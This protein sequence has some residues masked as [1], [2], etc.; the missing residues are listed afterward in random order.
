MYV[1]FANFLLKGD[2]MRTYKWT[3]TIKQIFIAV[4]IM[5]LLPAMA[6]CGG[7]SPNQA[8]QGDTRLTIYTTLYVL[9]EF[10]ERIGGDNVR[11]V[12]LIP[13]GVSP[14]D[15]EPS[16]RDSTNIVKGDLFI[17]NGAGM[18]LWISNILTNL[19]DTKVTAVNAGERALLLQVS[20]NKHGGYDPHT[21]IS[22]QN[23]II[24]AET[25]KDAL[26]G[27]DYERQSYYEN[28]YQN[29]ASELQ[30]LDE[31]YRTELVGLKHQEFYISHA[32][33]GY[34]AAAYGLE[35]RSISG[36]TSEDEPSLSEMKR[37]T[38]RLTQDEI[39]YI[40]VDKTESTKIAEVLAREL[41]IE[42][43]EIYTIGSLYPDQ[44]AAGLNYNK[45]MG[46]NLEALKKALGE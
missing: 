11:A 16:A 5:V 46:L 13:A 9:Q 27:L 44:A 12:N 30:A 26:V 21:W 39:K 34:L 35:Q 23:A 45:L 2:P 7:V 8:N 38:E 42:T 43:L 22:P 37:L 32:A 3:R 40:L 6:G 20:D 19:R 28:N 15:Y 29:L 31:R 33:F 24:I 4:M 25:I 10:A 14:H 18:E 17:Y 1:I 41:G 36:Y